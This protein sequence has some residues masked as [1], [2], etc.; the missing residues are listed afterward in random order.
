M[1]FGR[2]LLRP[3]A[4]E[5]I[6]P[7]DLAPE[8]RSPKRW[9]YEHQQPPERRIGVLAG[10]HPGARVLI[11]GTGPSAKAVLPY[12]DH[13]HGR[14]DVVIGLNGSVQHLRNLDYF[15]SV[16]SKAY[17]WD[18]YHF[19]TD[20]RV[21]RCVSESGL[22]LAA[23]AGRPDTQQAYVLLRHVYEQPVDL[24]AYGNATGEEGLL[25]GPRGATGLGRGTVTL[26]A[27]HFA[28][29]LGARTI[30]VIGA[31]LHFKPGTQHFYG[32]NE[33]GTHIVDG[34]RYHRLDTE[35]RLNPIVE[36]RHPETGERVETTLHFLESAD[37]IDHVARTLLPPAGIELVDFSHGLLSAPAKADI[38]EYMASVHP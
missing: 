25:V 26:Q 9:L 21:I 10:R 30:H 24:R 1:R 4:A 8:K 7:T 20:P 13:L 14:W 18:W 12:D 17:L 6:T 34:R 19:G 16:E 2:M 35:H 15:L 5:A 33:Y 11:V 38:H 23:E 36:T 29:I 22:R 3:S 32:G 31:D 37:Y 27:I 28:S